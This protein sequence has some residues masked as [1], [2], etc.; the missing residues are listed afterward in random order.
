MGGEVMH[1]PEGLTLLCTNVF[2]VQNKVRVSAVCEWGGGVRV[3]GTLWCVCVWGGG[4]C[5]GFRVG[6]RFFK[7]PYDF[8]MGPKKEG[9]NRQNYQF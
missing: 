9:Q 4:G 1:P 2:W 8:H 5:F 6:A 3:S 7:D